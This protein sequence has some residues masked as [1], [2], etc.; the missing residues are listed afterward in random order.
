V[1]VGAQG[2]LDW[3]AV[4][5]LQQ[6]PPLADAPPPGMTFPVALPSAL[7]RDL[8]GALASFTGWRAG[9]PVLVLANSRLKLAAEPNEGRETFRQ[10]C[11]LAADKAD[12]REQDAI[13]ARY[14]K[15]I[16]TLKTRLERERGELERDQAQARA[17]TME[18]GLTVV[19]GLFSV[20]LGSRGMRSAASKAISRTRSVATQQRMR[21]TA[22]GSVAESEREIERLGGEIEDLAR[23]L[24]AEVGRVAAASEAL[25]E[26]VEEVPIRPKRSDLQVLSVE[27]VWVG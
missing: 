24:D 13:R 4:E 8:K 3:T 23:E 16:D 15:R 22:Q 6:E 11:L 18:E 5:R 10:R 20:L 1:P 7:E 26:A 17:R 19:E 25:A 9:Q 27:L 14:E 2:G 12:D 21:Q